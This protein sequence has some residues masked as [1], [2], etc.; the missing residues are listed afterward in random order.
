MIS[1]D[2]KTQNVI[3]LTKEEKDNYNKSVSEES[4]KLLAKYIFQKLFEQGKIY[5][6]FQNQKKTKR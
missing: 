1:F 6:I 3:I 5:L 2:L 4:R